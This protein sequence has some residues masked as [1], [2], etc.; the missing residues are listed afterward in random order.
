[1][2][3]EK[4]MVRGND[5]C[6]MLGLFFD[7]TERIRQHSLS[8]IQE[9]EKIIEEQ[10]QKLAHLEQPNAAD[11]TMTTT[12]MS[13]MTAGLSTTTRTKATKGK[14]KKKKASGSQTPAPNIE[15]NPKYIYL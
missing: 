10:A 11:L 8:L 3:R 12:N 5:F 15:E 7:L 1:M 14:K 9:R 2:N 13:A 6:E 4:T